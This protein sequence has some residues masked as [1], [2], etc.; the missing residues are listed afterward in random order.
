MQQ[1]QQ[2]W[3]QDQ[4]DKTKTEAGLR[5]RSCHKTAASYPKTYVYCY[6][7]CC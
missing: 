1:T 5:Q 7:C 6:N 3:E 4:K 2:S